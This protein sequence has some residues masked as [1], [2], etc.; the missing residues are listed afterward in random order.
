MS[1][2]QLFGFFMV[3]RDGDLTEMLQ[4][5]V[6]DGSTKPRKGRR[7]VAAAGLPDPY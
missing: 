1:Q 6:R 4:M 2:G 3:K 7:P 5:L